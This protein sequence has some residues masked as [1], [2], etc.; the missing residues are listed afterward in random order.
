MCIG[1]MLGCGRHDQD[2]TQL[3]RLPW[4]SV[5]RSVHILKGRVHTG[6]VL[7]GVRV[8]AD[9]DQQ[10]LSGQPREII[11]LLPLA[12]RQAN[13]PDNAAAT[14]AAFDG[15]LVSDGERAAS[16]WLIAGVSPSV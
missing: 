8:V 6:R 7:L 4:W 3:D 12:P 16:Y 9:E 5:R 11:E 13:P 15:A 2:T 10:L 14:I 1:Q